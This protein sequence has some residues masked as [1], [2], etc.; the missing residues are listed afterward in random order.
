LTRMFSRQDFAGLSFEELLKDL[1]APATLATA[2]KYI[3]LLWGDRAHENLMKSINPLGQLEITTDNG[4]GGK[5]TRYLQFD[6][7]RVMGPEGIRHV[8][9]AVGDITSSVL[10]AREL[11]DSQENANA[12]VDMMLSML[13]VDPLQ[14]LSFLDTAETSLKLVNT[15][16]KEPARTD[17]EF[18]KKLGGLF[19]E[20]HGIKGEASA[21][22]LKSIASR[23][24]A[25]EDMVSDC[26]KKP[27]LSGNDFL[28]LVLKLDDLLAHLRS[29]REMAAR[30]T[31]LKETA[32]AA[33]AAA[34][35]NG[36]GGARPQSRPVEDLSPALQAMAERLAQDHAK[37][38]RLTVAGLGEVPLSYATIIKDCLIQMLR[39]AAVHGIEPPEVRRAHTK[40]D[41]GVV[42]VHFRKTGDGYELVFE[43]DGA[44]IATEALKAAAVRKQLIS[45]EEARGMDTRAAMA[46]I[47]RPGFTTQENVSMDAGRG[48]G[49]DV[50]ARSV[51]AL[52]GKIGVSTHPGRF[53]R[54]KILLPAAQAVST[55]VA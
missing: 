3:K 2:T 34:A 23:V 31:T 7:H 30:L 39:N 20:L 19:R 27:A 54:F 21:L 49:M 53:T 48:V 32:P 26:K 36:A 40:Q 25:L 28:P 37:R 43:D 45:E 16:L 50:V 14:L 33:G 38:F 12:Q 52:G 1:V 55:A 17:A 13:H 29:V 46:L 15:I 42:S 41:V 18:R 8:L 9:C 5:E 51:Y 44:G 35:T 4:H 6:F 22:N 11:Q 47:F 10:L 24:H